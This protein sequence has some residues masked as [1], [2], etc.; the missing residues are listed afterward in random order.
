[1]KEKK[2]SLVISDWNMEPVTDPLPEIAEYVEAS[3]DDPAI[4]RALALAVMFLVAGFI[5]AASR[6]LSRSSRRRC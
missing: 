1:M 5:G 3:L 6:P 2:Y 4:L